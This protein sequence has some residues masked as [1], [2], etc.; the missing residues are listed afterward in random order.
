MGPLCNPQ[1]GT[2]ICTLHP[3]AIYTLR[4]C[5]WASMSPSG[6]GVATEE[7]DTMAWPVGSEASGPVGLRRWLRDGGTRDQAGLF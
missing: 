1:P 7:A 5:I 4:G 6:A 3:P 2:D